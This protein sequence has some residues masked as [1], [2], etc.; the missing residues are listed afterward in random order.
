MPAGCISLVLVSAAL[1]GSNAADA[2]RGG[3]RVIANSEHSGEIITREVLSQ[4]FLR[5]ARRWGDGLHITAVDQ[6]AESEV[7]ISF[8]AEV[9]Q[10]STREVINY[11]VAEINRG[12]HPPKVKASDEEVIAFVGATKGAIGYVSAGARLTGQVKA[13]LVQD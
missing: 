2:E 1:L 9:L 3:F 5:K 4:V 11:W 7:R 12:N 6:S 13:L 8:T 10:S